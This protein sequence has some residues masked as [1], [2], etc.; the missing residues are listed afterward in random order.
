M[1][2][3]TKAEAAFS[4]RPMM[5]RDLT[6][7][8]AIATRVHSGYFEAAEV[9]AERL[10]LFP[11]GCWIAEASAMSDA[12][13]ASCGDS[14][15]QACGYA[16]MHPARL[17]QP[18]ALNSLLQQLDGAANCLYLHDVA[19]MD[20]ARGAGLGRSLMSHLRQVMADA[21][22][23]YAALIAVNNSASYWAACGFRISDPD[24][25]LKEKLASYDSSAAYMVLEA[26]V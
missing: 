16:I 17:R 8:M 5:P 14:R 12:A 23:R 21:D 15:H 13:L 20:S 22:L 18:P 4:W 2:M 9:F 6:T 26:D 10:H 11:A 25:A 3:E 19:L 1:M 7:V 24:P